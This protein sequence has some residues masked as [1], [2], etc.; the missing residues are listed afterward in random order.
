MSS[1]LAHAAE[2]KGA[3]QVLFD[4]LRAASPLDAP[5]IRGKVLERLSDPSSDTVEIFLDRT[6]TLIE[7]GDT[8]ISKELLDTV[9]TLAPNFAHG[10]ALRGSLNLRVGD[11]EAARTDLLQA[12]TLEPRHIPARLALS[13]LL[14]KENAS[15]EAYEVLRNTLVLDPQ[16][17]NAL[18]QLDDLR[19]KLDGQ[20]I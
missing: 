14:I 19:P 12:I 11:L 2:P 20:E 5:A 18:Q 13:S 15:K 1:G 16:N 4:E 8:A 3:L 9:V 7:N 6:E 10:F 17:P